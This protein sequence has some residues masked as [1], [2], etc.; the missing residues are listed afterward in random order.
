MTKALRKAIMKRSELEREYVKNKA[1]ENLK[2]YKK[3]KKFCSNLYKKERK[4]YY[5]RLDLNN[6]TNTKKF[7]KTITPFL[8]DKVTFFPQI[9]LVENDEIIS[10]ESKVAN[11]SSNFFENAVHSLGIKTNES[12]NDKHDL[13]NPVEIA[14]KKYE[15]HPSINPIKENI[16]N[17]ESFHFL[18]TEQESILKEITNL[19]N[20]K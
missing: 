9:I 7:W 2:S 19:D 11:S 13:K 20:K 5:E 17:N 3:Q 6:I 4:K 10:D 1:S 12:T 15:Q 18:P 14:I 16:T 8:S